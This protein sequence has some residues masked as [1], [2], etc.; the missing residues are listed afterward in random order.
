MKW[1]RLMA[2][3]A[4]SSIALVFGAR[5]LNSSAAAAPYGQSDRLAQLSLEEVFPVFPAAGSAASH[6][7][8]TVAQPADAT[9]L[10]TAI[11]CGGVYT[12][13]GDTFV[14]QSQPGLNFGDFPL[15]ISQDSSGNDLE[16][17]LLKF[18]SLAGALPP[19]ATIQRAELELSLYQ[20]PQ[21]AT[22]TLEVNSQQD[23]TWVESGVTWSTQPI[24]A[25]GFGPVTYAITHTQPENSIVRLDV[26]P[27]ATMWASGAI[28]NTGLTITPAG[29][30][31]LAVSFYG[32][33]N[34]RGMYA[35]RL[36]IY[37][38]PSK[39]IIPLDSVPG[40]LRQLAGLNRL[41]ATSAV[42]STLRLERGSLRY[43]RFQITVPAAISTTGYARASWFTHVYSDALR[44]NDPDGELQLVRR[45]PDDRH[46]FFRQLHFGI[47]V[48]PSEI[49][50][51][52][53]AGQVTGV[54]GATVPGITV[55]PTPQLSAEQAETIALAL[56]GPPV[57]INGDTQLVYLNLGLVGAPDKATYLAWQVN[58]SNGTGVFIDANNGALLYEQA[59]NTGGFDLDLNT[60]NH[61][62]PSET[63]CYWHYPPW[64]S[65][66]WGDASGVTS[67]A[68]TEGG[69][70]WWAIRNVWAFWYWTL[71]TNSY[72][73][74]GAEVEL[75][76]HT[77][78]F[79]GVAHWMPDCDYFEFTDG[80]AHAQ[81]LVGHEYTHAVMDRGPMPHFVYSW[82]SGAL[83]ESFAD[84]FGNFAEGDDDWFIGEDNPNWGGRD[85]ANPARD[86]MSKTACPTGGDK[87]CVHS[88]NGVHN[89]VAYLV[90]KGGQFNGYDM[91][92][93]IGTLKATL[94]F[95]DM[96][97]RLT[98]NADFMQARE[99]AIDVGEYLMAN[100]PAVQFTKT[101]LCIVIRAYASVGLGNGD[102]NCDGK[103]DTVGTDSD[104]DH[105]PDSY[106]N[107]KNVANTGQEDYNENG[108]GDACDPNS[109]G[110]LY[111]DH[112]FP[113]VCSNGNMTDCNDNCPFTVQANQND[114]NANAI[115][116]ACENSDGDKI[117]D[118][119][120]NCGAAYNPDQIK[121]DQ[122]AWG[123]VCD[124]DDDNDGVPDY[125]D[126]CPVNYNP[127]QYDQ[128]A[129]V[130]GNWIGDGIGNA[131]DL[132]PN[133]L[134]TYDNDDPDKDNMANP[135]DLDDDGDG[136]LDD[137][138][139]SG[140][141]SDHPCTANQT[142]N[143]DDNCRLVKN[144]D[145]LDWNK[146]GLGSAC[147]HGDHPQISLVDESHSY[148]WMPGE[149]FK[150]PL[151]GAGDHPNWGND[152]LGL[153]YKEAIY[154][155][156]NVDVF[157]EIVNNSGAVLA[158]SQRHG[159]DLKKQVLSFE[160][161]P[162]VFMGGMSYSSENSTLAQ[163]AT[164]I[165]PG[166]MQYYLLLLPVDTTP[167]NTP[168]TV[169][170][171]ISVGPPVT[172]FLPVVRK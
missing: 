24:S 63:C 142:A 10:V 39:T 55:D 66:W 51:H 28:T 30:S 60:A 141:D 136:V 78:W 31:A 156:S 34:N 83:S 75:Y 5:Q 32:R 89:K 88:N 95:Y 64:A 148:A 22:Y 49:G 11:P 4:F 101:D 108:I 162:F 168:V 111:P 157:A 100:E 40:N 171:Q 99:V 45:S 106:D 151:P 123:D 158:K 77:G 155:E 160:P 107:C 7:A 152:Y 131:C 125:P 172:L 94:L 13:T 81:D 15:L 62:G 128:D 29:A 109:D 21:P 154:L 47:P 86:M 2:V 104:Y 17:I 164:T 3:F 130:N 44:L 73:R 18:D 56:A 118:D 93:G 161:V 110:D 12:T 149:A 124:P 159:G 97:W 46:I 71:G 91:K 1:L 52:L 35:P 102:W 23:T 150:I 116:D 103:E 105:I 25:I 143:C 9:A 33:E 146:N 68:D 163:T 57:L 6:T 53:Q 169:T 115:G 120:D 84:I 16:R 48:Y 92:S 134:N 167:M 74:E 43:G 90:T 54:S 26:T 144:A 139:L 65:T 147:E 80:S 113:A 72:D 117:T 166:W 58:L 112:Q 133:S 76:I 67:K 38:A 69:E 140:S 127:S 85:M 19:G 27:W 82:W 126:N 132:C 96:L 98:S 14:R 87:G 138:N 129:Y 153:G 41:Q 79:D 119:K 137:G 170:L 59:D 135:C 145:Q 122:D 42:T 36:K 37:C 20:D 50:V 8:S 121:S 165:P 70:A 61:D 114:W